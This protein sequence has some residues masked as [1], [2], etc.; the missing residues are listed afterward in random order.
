MDSK[1]FPRKAL[2][3]GIYQQGLAQ[4]WERA[5]ALHSI[6]DL[7]IREPFKVSLKDF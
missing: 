1:S 4:S 5:N 2:H 6:R 3:E 7:R